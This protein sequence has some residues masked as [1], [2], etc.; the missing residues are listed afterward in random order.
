MTKDTERLM[1]EYEAKFGVPFPLRVLSG[2]LEEAIKK[3]LDSGE[4]YE[5]D[6]SDGKVY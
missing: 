2:S 3:S 1:E 4:E 6:M 5:P